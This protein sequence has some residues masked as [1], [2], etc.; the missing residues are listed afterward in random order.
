MRSR[1]D[2][3]RQLLGLRPAPEFEAWLQA[4]GIFN[5]RGQI[6]PLSALPEPFGRM[7]TRLGEVSA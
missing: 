5:E 1:S 2:L 7:L 6:A 4:L 3:I